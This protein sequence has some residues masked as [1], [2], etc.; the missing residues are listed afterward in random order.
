MVSR[1]GLN[2]K[3][4]KL[5]FHPCS[6]PLAPVKNQRK[7]DY[8]KKCEKSGAF[9]SNLRVFFK[10][11]QSHHLVD[12]KSDGEEIRSQFAVLPP[13]LLHQSHHKGAAHLVVLWLVIL[14]QQ[15]E[16]VLRV[17]PESVCR[18]EGGTV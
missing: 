6:P 5:Q 17:G 18:A 12:G 3:Y 9:L 8:R 4:G 13:V 10:K 1:S 14:L 2:W 11:N 16:T 7:E 15:T